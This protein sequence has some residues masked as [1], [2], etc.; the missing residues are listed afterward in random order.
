M[1]AEVRF[2][3][4]CS[5]QEQDLG[6]GWKMRR[7]QLPDAMALLMRC[8][9]G[10]WKGP[11]L[12]EVKVYVLD[13]VRGAQMDATGLQWT[14]EQRKWFERHMKKLLEGEGNENLRS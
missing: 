12:W 6:R 3:L 9:N 1:M 11:R 10:R 5:S 14:N 8:I 4:Y 7:Q 13:H 2:S